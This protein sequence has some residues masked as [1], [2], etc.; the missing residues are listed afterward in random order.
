MREIGP[1]REI[2]FMRTIISMRKLWSPQRA[3]VLIGLLLPFW[4]HAAWES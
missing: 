2:S 4:A 1:F 3:S